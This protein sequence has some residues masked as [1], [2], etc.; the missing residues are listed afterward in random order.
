VYKLLLPAKNATFYPLPEGDIFFTS[1]YIRRNAIVDPFKSVVRPN[2]LRLQYSTKKI[3][4]SWQ[5]FEDNTK[6]G[7]ENNL[8]I[9]IKGRGRKP[10]QIQGD[11][12]ARKP[13]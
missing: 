13:T 10:L 6:N 7:V 9:V 5:F 4:I 12:N 11:L 8:V 2:E 1:L 3:L